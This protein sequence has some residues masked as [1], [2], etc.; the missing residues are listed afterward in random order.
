[1][2]GVAIRCAD[3]RGGWSCVC[4]WSLGVGMVGIGYEK[5]DKKRHQ[6]TESG[7]MY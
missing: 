2:D 3:E 6:D 4:Y 7:I 5:D 1:M